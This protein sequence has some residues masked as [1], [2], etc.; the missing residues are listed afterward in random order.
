MIKILVAEDEEPIANLVRIN[1]TKAGYQV[2]LAYD[3]QE[4]ADNWQKLIMIWDYLIL[5]FHI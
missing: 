1:L 5:C 2:D 4:A 3:G